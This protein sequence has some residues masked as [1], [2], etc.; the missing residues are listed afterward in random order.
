MK[1]K[2]L[3]AWRVLVA[4]GMAG[5][6]LIA[7]AIALVLYRDYKSA[8]FTRE[9]WY[10]NT[11][12][13][14]YSKNTVRIRDISSGK[15]LTPKLTSICKGGVSDTLTVFFQGEKR[16]FLNVHTGKIEI[17][18]KYQKA[19]IFSEGLGAV[20]MN[21]KVGFINKKGETVIPCR[22]AYNSSFPK[23]VDFL[24]KSGYCTVFDDSG[25]AGLIDKNGKWVIQPQYD[26]INPPR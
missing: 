12:Q 17:P 4:A 15:F 9:I 21:G 6:L 25:K 26:Y 16:G 19:W 14:E 23:T 20:V 5:V 18:A 3:L 1:Q 2:L 22:Y 11:F 7:G 8:Y 10:N 13:Y 24:F